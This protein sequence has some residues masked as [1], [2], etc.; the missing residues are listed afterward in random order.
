MKYKNIYTSHST[1]KKLYFKNG[2][3]FESGKYFF[4]H[5]MFKF[6]VTYPHNANLKYF[7][8]IKSNPSDIL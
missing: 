1:V 2:M 5:L 7:S 6:S 3:L 8:S 4:L